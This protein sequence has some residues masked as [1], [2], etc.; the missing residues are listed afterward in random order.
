MYCNCSLRYP[1]CNAHAPYCH[2]WP[3][4]LYITFPHYLVSSTVFET[5]KMEH[6]MYAMIFSTTFV[7]NLSRSMKNWAR[8]DKN[9]YCASCKAPLL[10]LDFNETWIFCT[11]FRKILK[12]QISFKSDQ[13][14]TSC[15]M[16]TDGQT[17][18]HK[19]ARRRFSQFCGRA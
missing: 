18:R 15:S 5:K 12:Y 6:K 8:Y 13:C 10:L 19:D 4:W 1:A 16:R 3:V 14:E 17:Y 9:V 7:W 2:L 11:D